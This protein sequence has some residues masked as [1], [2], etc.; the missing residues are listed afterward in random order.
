MVVLRLIET[1]QAEVVRCGKELAVHIGPTRG[2][3]RKVT[4]LKNRGIGLKIAAIGI[5]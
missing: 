3:I 2:H 1:K 5:R 4:V